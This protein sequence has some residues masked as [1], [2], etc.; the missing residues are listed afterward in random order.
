M[1]LQ[2]IWILQE[3][4]T[5]LFHQK[6]DD[7]NNDENLISGFL[8]A[9]NS[10]VGSFGAE[11]KWIETNRNRFVFKMRDQLIFVACTNPSEHAPLTYKR[12]NRIADH[13]DLMFGKEF[14]VSG[15]PIPIDIFKKIAPTVNRLF[16]IIEETKKELSSESKEKIKQ[17]LRFDS[18]E[19]RLMS[20][21]RYKR[22][23][24][25]TDIVRYLRISDDDAES[26]LTKLETNRFV[27]KMERPDGTE[28]YGLHPVVRGA[29]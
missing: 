23:V 28:Q 3:S 24:S 13:F 6:Y 7:S 1:S 22:R 5:C 10:F 27:Q 11:I 15:D 25:V 14:L 12:L 17:E 20:F 8:S 19:A 9:V 2:E 18:K 29:F 26:T 16:G 4:G 21:I